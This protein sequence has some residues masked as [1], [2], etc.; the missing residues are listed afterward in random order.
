MDTL[1]LELVLDI[2]NKMCLITDKRQL[3]RTCKKYNLLTKEIFIEYASNYVI[4][5]FDKITK[6]CV[7]KFTL[8]LCYDGYF[9]M[10]PEHYIISGNKLLIKSLSYFGIVILLE[11]C[12]MKGFNM[13]TVCEYAALNGHLSVLQWARENGCEWNSNT[14]AFAAKNGHLSVL[15]WSHKNGCEWNSNTCAFAAK[16]GHLPVLQWACANGC[17]WDNW[18]CAYAALNGHLSVLQWVRAN[19]CKWD[20]WT[21][22]YAARNGHLSVLQWARAN[23]CSWDNKTYAYAK[24]NN[25]PEL[26]KWALENGCPE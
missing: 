17:K 26:L 22:A 19:G 15:Q 2:F 10:I 6:Y 16:N 8:E 9:E 11:L 4:K 1:P 5:D 3:L 21:C 24:K 18:T 25:H 7:E 23:G 14:C 12:K 13:N 20:N